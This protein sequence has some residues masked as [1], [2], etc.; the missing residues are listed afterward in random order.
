MARDP[1]A[2]LQMSG[3][4]GDPNAHGKQ[5]H[6]PT[7]GGDTK[8]RTHVLLWGNLPFASQGQVSQ[9]AGVDTWVELGEP[10]H[11]WPT[12]LVLRG[13][14]GRGPGGAEPPHNGWG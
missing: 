11:T 6:C 13:E 5:S 1:P 3:A 12:T 8:Q 2:A 9:Q 14:G 7:P 4:H 10:A